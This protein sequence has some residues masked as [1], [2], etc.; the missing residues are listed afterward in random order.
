MS[1]NQFHMLIVE[2]YFNVTAKLTLT[3]SYYFK[4]CLRNTNVLK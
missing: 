2:K 3:D 1:N 4:M